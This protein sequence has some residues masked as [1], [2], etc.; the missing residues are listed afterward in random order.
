LR[1]ST[2]ASSESVLRLMADLVRLD[3]PTSD[4]HRPPAAAEYAREFVR[5]GAS[6]D[7]LLRAYHVGQ[8]TF[9][10]NWVAGVRAEISDFPWLARA[11][12]LGARWTFDYIQT[13]NRE[14]VARYESGLE[15]WVRSAAAVR[16]ETVRALLADESIDPAQASRLLR[17]ELGRHH[18]A[19][20]V[21]S[22]EERMAEGDFGTLERAALE[23]AE[24]IG[25]S[26]PLVPFGPQLVAAWIGTFEPIGARV[27]G[28]AGAACAAVGAPGLGVVGFCTSHGEAMH[29]RRVARLAA[30]DAA[31]VTHYEDVSLT[32]LASVDLGLASEFATRELRDL[33]EQDEDNLSL[34]ATLRA[35]REENASPLWAAHRLGV[36]ES[37]IKNRMRAIGEL[38]DGPPE[39]A[40]R[41]AWWRC[42]SR[43]SSTTRLLSRSWGSMPRVP[44]PARVCASHLRRR[45]RD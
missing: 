3:R 45:R 10:R 38:L 36:H 32:A 23:L 19:Y 11:V 28:L 9:F 30:R 8:K 41:S 24:S 16:A 43:I 5:S 31:G 17:Y 6:I 13:L 40:S 27:N 33:A 29:A 35:Y 4:G 14:L 34:S 39:D 7:T 44:G 37:T 25:A 20:V 21:W 42:G 1:N 2:F 15:Q 22:G 18:L 26:T 12:E